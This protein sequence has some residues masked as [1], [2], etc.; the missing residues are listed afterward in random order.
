MANSRYSSME[1]NRKTSPKEY[2]KRHDIAEG[3]Y[4]EDLFNIKEVE[5]ESQERT[6]HVSLLSG[7]EE[8]SH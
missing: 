5:E 1:L 2:S 6:S 3:E 7:K 4:S 8:I